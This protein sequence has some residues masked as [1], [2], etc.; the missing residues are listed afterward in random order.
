[1]KYL[2][3]DMKVVKRLYSIREKWNGAKIHYTVKLLDKFQCIAM[4]YYVISLIKIY[5]LF[6]HRFFI[7]QSINQLKFY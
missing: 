7:N 5:A 6:Y 1:L 4:T 2:K 3:M